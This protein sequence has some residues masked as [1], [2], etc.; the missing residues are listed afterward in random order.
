MSNYVIGLTGG[1]ACGKTNLSN[2][3]RGANVPVIDADLISR[4]LTIEGG[5]ALPQIRRAFG[6][7]VFDGEILNRKR[8]GYLAFSDPEA[9]KRLNGILHPMIF[10]R[11]KEEMDKQPGPVVLD[12]PLLF[13]TGL[14]EWC[15]EIWCAFVPPEI[16]LERLMQR[17]RC[18]QEQA[19]QRINAQ[20]PA[21]EKAS[22]SHRVIDTSGSKQ[23]SAAIVLSMWNARWNQLSRPRSNNAPGPFPSPASIRPAPASSTNQHLPP[24]RRTGNAQKKK[25]GFS[26]LQWAVLI[27]LTAGVSIAGITWLQGVQKMNRVR[28]LRLAQEQ[29][30]IRAQQEYET[31]VRLHQVQYEEWIRYYSAEYQLDPAYVA[32]IIKTES[33]YNPRA[34]SNKNA[35]GLMQ[36]M[37]DTL[38]WVGPKFGVSSKDLNALNDPEK[39]IQMGCYLLNY[40]TKQFDGDPVLTACA[41]HAG[42]GNVEGWIEKYSTDGKTLTY[43]QIPYENSRNYARKVMNSYAIYQQ[44]Y[45]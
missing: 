35:R 6:D 5:A 3:L 1:I 10:Q 40:I 11:M 28:G 2:A 29:E 9:L 26:A 12:V 24:P 8:L 7:S 44:Y 30:F 14:N 42:W 13:E 20:M 21:A 36:F 27:L 33:N 23:D 16:Q 38:E 22:R 41:Y 34:V 31:Q 18:T 17:D 4:S 19:M 32:A 25:K 37:P 43:D 15:D 39:A 45:Y